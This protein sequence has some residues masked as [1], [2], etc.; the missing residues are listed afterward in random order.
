MVSAEVD[1]EVTV[2]AHLAVG[3]APFTG[4][5]IHLKPGLNYICWPKQE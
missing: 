5:S 2:C 3:R 4:W 1:T